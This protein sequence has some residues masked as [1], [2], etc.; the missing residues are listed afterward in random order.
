MKKI[1]TFMFLIFSINVCAQDSLVD[2]IF[3]NKRNNKSQ[4]E[5][6]TKNNLDLAGL[7][8]Q[9][10]AKYQYGAIGCATASVGLF[11][12]A[13]FM[14]DSYKMEKGELI[15][16]KNDTRTALIIG[17]S[18]LAFAAVC[19]E[20]YSIDLKMK[21]GRSIKLFANGNGGGLAYTF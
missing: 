4:Q 3:K 6:N 13:S 5:A 20:L 8:L 18:V 21:A 16:D 11:I 9:Q 14:Q 15:K 17:G 12:G 1:I 2:L 7:Q 10:S 19:C